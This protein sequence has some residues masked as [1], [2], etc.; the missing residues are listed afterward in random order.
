MKD[1]GG[2]KLEPRKA[3]Q[4]L[5]DILVRR[6]AFLP[7]LLPQR[8]APS[9]ALLEIF[10]R[11]LQV[12]ISRLNQAPDK[13][14]L[15]FLDML[16]LSLL[17]AQAAR[18]PVV[19]QPLPEAVDG[20]IPAGTR[21]GAMATGQSDPISFETEHTI[22]LTGARLV[23]VKTVWPAQDSYAD[24]TL[25]M[26]GGQPFR[27]FKP[28]Q[29]VAHELYLSH[30]RLFAFK[31]G[32][33][34][35]IAADLGRTGSAPL[36]IAW[37]Y[38]DGQVWRGFKP[39]DVQDEPVSQDGTAGFTRSGVITL[40]AE[41]GQSA[42]KQVYG[43]SPFWV[44]GRLDQ[45][46]PPDP[47]A[48][49]PTL[50][51]LRVRAAMDRPL[52][53]DCHTGLSPD[54]AFTGGS[55]LDLSK[56]F[57]PLGRRPDQD[58]VFYFSS[59]EVFSKP[60]AQVT[61]CF[62]EVQTPEKEAAVL[63]KQY[64]LDVDKAKEKL[65]EIVFN[66]ATVI[67]D[68]AKVVAVLAEK[69]LL[70][71]LLDPAKDLGTEITNLENARTELSLTHELPQLWDAIEK[72]RDT[73]VKV[74][75]AM[76]PIIVG[77][78]YDFFWGMKKLNE[79]ITKQSIYQAGIDAKNAVT[80]AVATLNNLVDLS[81]MEAAAAG[82]KA[83][84]QLSAPELAWEY[85]NGRSWRD[86][87][88]AA[89]SPE[90][91]QFLAPGSITFSVPLDLEP[92]TVNGLTAR[93]L[94]VRLAA[95]SFQRLRLVSWYDATN[96][97]TNFFPIIE[98]HPPVLCHLFLGYAY[99]SPW[100]QPEHCLTYN[101]FQFEW[102]SEAA[103]W[104]GP[105]F[106]PFRAMTDVFPTL[107]LGF[108]RPLPNDLISLYLD[109]EEQEAVA[110]A[111]EWECWDGKNW[112]RL[113]VND[114]TANFTQ[115]GM[116]TFIAPEVSPRP[117]VAISSA[118]GSYITLKNALEAAVFKAGDR[119]LLQQ[120]DKKETAVIRRIQGEVLEPETPLAETYSGG[121]ITLAGLPRFGAA[122][123]W[124]RARLQEGD[125]PVQPQ[126]LGIYANATWAL[127]VQTVENELL[128]SGTGE[129]QQ[130]CF[131]SH[132]PVL[133]GEQVEVRELEGQRAEVELPLLREE[134]L[135]Q[136]FS[137]ED[138]RLVHDPRTGAVKEV[139]VCW[140]H[141]PYLFFSGP[142]ERHYR[143][144]RAKGRLC[145][146]DGQH[147][148]LPTVGANNIRSTRYRA[149][150]GLPGNVPAGKIIQ[151]LSPVPSVQGVTNP[152]AADGG[153]DG[154][155]LF[156]VKTR[157]PQDLRHRWR[158]LAAC[159]YEALAKE[160]APGVA[161]ARALPATAPNGRPAPG[162]VTVIIVPQ[163]LEPQPHPSL[164]L[165][166]RVQEYLWTRTPATVS[167]QHL[168]V[169]GP[170]YLPVGVRARV[171]PLQAEEAGGL[172]DDIRAALSA[173]LHPLR[174]GVENYGGP[175]GRNVYLS[176]VASVL[177][178]VAGVDYVTELNLLLND[179]PQGDCV[180]V[181]ADR[182]VVA[183]PVYLEMVA[184]EG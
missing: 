80:Q 33:T 10:V 159:D 68:A 73:A 174:G 169:V 182:I 16:G 133:P 127:Q 46:L 175:F 152:R 34:V 103:R 44:R 60:G 97:M 149:G 15:A 157:G 178:G 171:A 96:R 19:F 74:Q 164:E 108:D 145:F 12:V 131:F 39:F 18:A 91:Q 71:G 9:W 162:W 29:P 50:Q 168:A 147:G 106:A 26:A 20:R 30:N 105:A 155:D 62:H 69:I 37:E 57:F 79:Q 160:A 61:L 5:Q 180:E 72:V 70:P 43:W 52:P 113:L 115:P 48:I 144:E 184:S 82:G 1:N 158:A 111:L 125:T 151:I 86:L 28:G 177:E 114:E 99:R 13:N 59:E 35:E 75:N 56:N 116:V 118:G 6:P 22:A 124:V 84:P 66:T 153:A 17:P 163:S 123:D 64:E 165:R 31:T 161:A 100:E 14:L 23:E 167:R 40:Q 136:G 67:I 32:A 148:K 58:S 42:S 109:L 3:A 8:G 25:A 141:R 7:E 140:R 89:S 117:R 93:W 90:V 65:K 47:A 78:T 77:A 166:R 41:C 2:L 173:F 24:H 81:P 88:L 11:Y 101:D 137:E 102:H 119:L 134:L 129:P 138:L 132:I 172:E 107:Y 179:V 120:D 122:L 55:R 142:E 98:N 143:L 130:S 110:P 76:S 183:G 51:R 154:E 121:T 112:R 139:W 87:S 146:G 181:P 128:G 92:A 95:G 104:P 53:P 126:F 83:P 94:R 49:L 85:W 45:P 36:Q 54:Q 176:D 156:G 27:L 135:Q 38:W 63:T 150:G 4:V 170:T 21:L